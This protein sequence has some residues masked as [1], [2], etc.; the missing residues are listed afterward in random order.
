MTVVFGHGVVCALASVVVA[1]VAEPTAT[2]VKPKPL[3][4]KAELATTTTARVRILFM[5]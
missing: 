4:R 1:E 5:T 3:A 2:A